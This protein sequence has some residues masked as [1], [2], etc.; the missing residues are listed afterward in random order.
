MVANRAPHQAQSATRRSRVRFSVFVDIAA[1]L[2]GSSVGLR[3]P[4]PSDS[5]S[6]PRRR[7]VRSVRLAPDHWS[8]RQGAP[9]APRR[10]SGNPRACP[11]S[12]SLEKRHVG[13]PPARRTGASRVPA[14]VGGAAA[15]RRGRRCLAPGRPPGVASRSTGGPSPSRLARHALPGSFGACVQCK[16]RGARRSRQ[17]AKAFGV[18]GRQLLVVHR[19]PP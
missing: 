17:A 6:S 1:S 11:D 13:V 2:L 18:G 10:A 8:Q 9:S 3:R 16:A 15:R 4:I 19:S 7:P 5:A 14:R 12:P